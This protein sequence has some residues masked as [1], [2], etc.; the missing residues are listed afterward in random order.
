MENELAMERTVAGG[1]SPTAVTFL[2]PIVVEYTEDEPSRADSSVT[3]CPSAACWVFVSTST[4]TDTEASPS[5]NTRCETGSV[6]P[7]ITCAERA[8][9][10][11][12]GGSL[13]AFQ[14]REAFSGGSLVGA[15]S[16]RSHWKPCVDT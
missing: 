8:A 2:P 1:T 4:K 14:T 5:L 3:V 7:G 13:S 15:D 9:I 10:L 12:P 11:K 6:E 16:S